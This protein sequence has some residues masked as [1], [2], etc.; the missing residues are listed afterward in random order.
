MKI[1]KKFF[2]NTFLKSFFFI[3]VILL[4]LTFWL[5]TPKECLN[6][7]FLNLIKDFGYGIISSCYT[8]VK[9]KNSIKS[10]LKNNELIYD[11]AAKV[12]VNFFKNFG[13]SRDL[14]FL[15][16]DKNKI[17]LNFSEND[18]PKNIKGLNLSN[19]I[20]ISEDYKQPPNVTKNFNNWSRSHG[21][22]WNNKF[23]DTDLI[24]EKNIS[25]LKLLWK[26]NSNQF[27]NQKSWKKNIGANPIFHDGILYFLSSDFTLNALYVETGKLIWQK[28][29]SNYP[30]PRGYLIN[31]ENNENYLYI[32][33]DRRLF[34]INAETGKLDNN[35]GLKG[36]I[37]GS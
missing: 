34:K 21:N 18:Q 7:N 25:K 2:K 14:N 17:Q 6:K 9:I 30:G 32:T 12:K 24:N 20:K 10:K 16:L 35:F 4:I 37:N 19:I 5:V 3:N 23:L 31:K 8:E 1:K 36:S 26:F 13:K 33:S 11:F 22:N 28:K 29:F 15:P 27:N